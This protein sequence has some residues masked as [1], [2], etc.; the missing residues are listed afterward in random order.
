MARNGWQAFFDATAS[1]YMDEEYAKPWREE[2][3]FYLEILNL[4]PGSRILDLGCGPV[5]DDTRW[6]WHG[7]AI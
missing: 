3:D 4:A 2:V 1:E 5:Q 7:G 6:N